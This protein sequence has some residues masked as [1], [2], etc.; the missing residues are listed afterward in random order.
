MLEHK[1]ILL[2]DK[3]GFTSRFLDPTFSEINGF[4]A[5]KL[6]CQSAQKWPPIIG[7]NKYGMKN[8]NG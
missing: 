8:E 2:I 5:C 4:L 1:A 7:E 6:P 3:M